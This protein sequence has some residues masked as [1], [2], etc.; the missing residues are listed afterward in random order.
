MLFLLWEKRKNTH[1]DLSYF[2]IKK[3]NAVPAAG[4]IYWTTLVNIIL[5]FSVNTP[6]K[7]FKSNEEVGISSDMF[8]IRL[9]QINRFCL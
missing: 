1:Y 8:R 9:N 5:I 4:L 7:L 6:K 2:K 3:C